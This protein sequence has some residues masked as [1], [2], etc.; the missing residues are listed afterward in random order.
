[1]AKLTP[2]MQQY[3][4]MK[5][6]Y[7][8][9]I[10]L[11]RMGDFYEVF[12]DDAKI[13]SQ[14]L[15]L[16][17][18]SRDKSAENP[19]PMAGLPY[20][21]ADKY[22][23][24]LIKNGYK[25]AIAEQTSEVVPGQLV[26]RAVSSIITPGTYIGD[27]TSDFH[28]T[29]G[30]TFAPHE[31]GMSH[32]VAWGDFSIG[33]YYT[34]SFVDM[35]E[36]QKFL[37]LL[38]PKEVVLDVDFP[39]LSEVQNLVAKAIKC[40][41]SVSDK[42]HDIPFVLKK[43]C[44]I[45][46]ISAFGKA[47]EDGR[48]TAFGLLVQY[49]GQT[50][51][52]AL[53]NFLSVSYHSSDG[54]LILDEVT[55][56]NLELFH[57]NYDHDSKYSLFSTINRCHT[58]SGARLLRFWLAHP[59]TTLETIRQRQN[60][61]QKYLESAGTL[62]SLKTLENFPDIPRLVSRLLYKRTEVTP[63]LRLRKLLLDCDPITSELKKFGLGEHDIEQLSSLRDLLQTLLKADEEITDDADFITDG[64]NERIDEY[65]RIAFKS[66]DALMAFYDEVVQKTGVSSI[67]VR[68]VSNAGYSLEVPER[69]IHTFER[70]IMHGDYKFGFLR[71]QTLKNAQRYTSP[72]LDE[73][74]ARILEAKEKLHAL[75]Y[76]LLGETKDTIKSF[77][78]ALFHLDQAIA[79]LDIAASHALYAKENHRIIPTLTV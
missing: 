67:K 12:F 23:D 24:K 70:G 52:S 8:D 26:S 37:L 64:Y 60:H 33:Q 74:E 10:L 42:P 72:Y 38:R 78:L 35:D 58:P 25:V 11:F 51:Q 54:S 15:D 68:F 27:T 7:K 21:S 43:T 30:L 44:N 39:N 55:I 28:Y 29:A 20:H 34:K 6:H 41:V 79:E 46:N 19:V 63:F 1:M 77:G 5:V 32:H 13:A 66:D 76:S 14:V 49:L 31:S 50:Q 4:D 18:T 9:C 65:R 3:M 36:V 2:A 53:H 56:K 47:L 69:D 16:R 45:Q 17:L 61:L 59:I 57:S 71:R 62:D 48:M 40:M 22:I 75:E 73:M